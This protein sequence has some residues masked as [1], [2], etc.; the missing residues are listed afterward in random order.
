MSDNPNTV[1]SY[2]GQYNT[3][4]IFDR[5]INYNASLDRIEFEYTM[6]QSENNGVANSKMSKKFFT[7]ALAPDAN[8]P[9]IVSN[10]NAPTGSHTITI[11]T[12]ITA[13]TGFEYPEAIQNRYIGDAIEIGYSIKSTGADDDIVHIVQ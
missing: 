11:W 9:G 10:G 12:P 3:P 4:V 5:K 7:S 1:Y 8:S 2:S 6:A 13:A